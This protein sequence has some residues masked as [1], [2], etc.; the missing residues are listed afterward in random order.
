LRRLAILAATAAALA[1]ASAAS[2]SLQPIRRAHRGDLGA[3]KFTGPLHIP[4]EH[5]R[6]RVRVIARL[7][8]PP[9][10]AAFSSDFA[11]GGSARRLDVQSGSSRRYIARLE[12][13][14][15]ESA[16]QIKAAIPGARVSRSFQV[17][18][19]G[20]T[21]D[22]PVRRLPDLAALSFVTQ[23]YPSLS[24]HRTLDDSPGLIRA[25]TFWAS[26]GARGEGMKIGVVDD[27]VDEKH[28]F[29]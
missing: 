27:G 8:L 17:V 23:L 4:A 29:L 26:T 10:A 12:A 28:I 25:T 14:Q 3:R 18:L 22:L 19:D 1:C 7:A 15:S 24:Y 21:V 16:R 13:M 5:D 9:L 2:S 6:G 20:L 11:L